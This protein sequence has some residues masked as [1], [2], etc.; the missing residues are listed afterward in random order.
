MT[1]HEATFRPGDL[2]GVYLGANVPQASAIVQV[3]VNGRERARLNVLAGDVAGAAVCEL[4]PD[5]TLR[6]TE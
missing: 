4:L 3:R 2:L 1:L 6:L 5:G